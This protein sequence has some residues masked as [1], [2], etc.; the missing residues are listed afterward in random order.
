LEYLHV[1]AAFCSEICVSWPTRLY[2][3]AYRVLYAVLAICLL[4]GSP[5]AC[6]RQPDVSRI[7]SASSVLIPRFQFPP[8]LKCSNGSQKERFSRATEQPFLQLTWKLDVARERLRFHRETFTNSF[9]SY[10]SFPGPQHGSFHPLSY[11]PLQKHYIF[12]RRL[13]KRHPSFFFPNL[14]QC[15]NPAYVTRGP[16]D[17]LSDLDE[18]KWT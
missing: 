12:S 7:S 15:P 1:V 2:P 16:F 14:Y 17:A 18:A 5:I 8:A 3:A 4:Y 11:S 13:T 9:M 6:F 10:K